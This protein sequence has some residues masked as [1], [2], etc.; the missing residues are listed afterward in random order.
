MNIAQRLYLLVGGAVI[1]LIVVSVVA[2]V[3]I[4]KVYDSANYANVNSLPSIAILDTTFRDFIALGSMINVAGI[5]ND[6]SKIDTLTQGVQTLRVKISDDF[7]KYE[8]LL[9]DDTDKQLLEKDRS[10]FAAYNEQS[11]KVLTALKENQV[12]AIHAQY[13]VLFPLREAV[14]A[15]LTVHDA[16]NMK[17]AAQGDIDAQAARHT[18]LWEGTILGIIVVLITVTQGILTQRSIVPPLQEAVQIAS[19]I[20]AGDLTH[21]IHSG[22]NNETGQ[23]LSA[24][25][26]MQDALRTTIG[27][28]R[29]HADALTDAASAMTETSGQVSAASANQSEASASM[30]AAVEQLAVSIA[31]VK[32]NASGAYDASEH[33]GS[34]SKE[35]IAVIHGA[36]EE[37]RGAANEIRETASM[38]DALGSESQRISSV[39]SVIRD[40]AEQTNLLALNASIE[41]ARAGEQGRGFAVVADEVRKLA[42]RTSSATSEISE[43]IQRVQG[44]TTQSMQGMNRAVERVNSGVELAGRAGDAIQKIAQSAEGASVAVSDIRSA[45]Y[46]QTAASSQIAS[47]VERIVQMAEENT[48]ASHSSAASAQ[49]LS[50]LAQEMRKTV[51]HFKLN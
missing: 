50:A 19:H 28:A 5:N 21:N 31:H 45:L 37:V 33:A 6:P 18:A 36:A 40:V 11:D 29:R 8:P 22:G 24:L 48:A 14:Q 4:G 41:A 20:A 17:L 26:A 7:K 43:T 13:Q 1:G 39:V 44:H 10:T 51:A 23:L 27:T 9:S 32:D 16:Y 35:G 30:A 49:A 47:T 34:L 15:S 42:E 3:Q 2:L 12:D 38:I 46:E 25:K